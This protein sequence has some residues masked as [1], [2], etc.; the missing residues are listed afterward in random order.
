M[1]VN[2]LIYYDKEHPVISMYL[3][4]ESEPQCLYSR[5]MDES[6]YSKLVLHSSYSN[7]TLNTKCW[8]IPRMIFNYFYEI[9]PFYIFHKIYFLFCTKSGLG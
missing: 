7:P 5:K 3:E 6:N 4:F 9:H 2:N 8:R 1:E